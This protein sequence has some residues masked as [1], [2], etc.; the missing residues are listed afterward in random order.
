MKGN[1][2]LLTHK[3]NEIMPITVTWMQL[4]IIMLSESERKRQILQDITY[5]W[6]LKYGTNEPILKRQ[7][8]TQRT[9]L[10]FPRGRGEGV[11]WIESLGL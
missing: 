1:G 11:G 9:D 2:I 8:Q 5:M 7:T 4:E 6:N 3:E 10:W